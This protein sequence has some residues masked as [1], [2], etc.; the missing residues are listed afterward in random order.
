MLVVGVR[1]LITLRIAKTTFEYVDSR[2]M[3]EAG[4]L[5][6]VMGMYMTLVGT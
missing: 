2:F 4:Q 1:N 3:I 6:D 5:S